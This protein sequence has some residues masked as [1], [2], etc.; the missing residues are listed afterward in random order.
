VP[1]AIAIH[2][3]KKELAKVRRLLKS[4][5]PALNDRIWQKSLTRYALKV[6]KQA[7][8]V[9]ID[10]GRGIDAPVLPRRLTWRTG[11][12][13]G[14]IMPNYDDLQKAIVYVGTDVEYARV[15]EF[16]MRQFLQPAV[17]H[18]M[19]KFGGIAKRVLEEEMSRVT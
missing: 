15:H 9:E 1:V 19:K 2:V 10:R 6:Q 4:V 17:D 8:E 13:G 18:T 16:G 12:L 5:S 7:S 11:Q 3:K 14:S